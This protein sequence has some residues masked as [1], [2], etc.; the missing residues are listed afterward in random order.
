MSLVFFNTLGSTSLLCENGSLL[1]CCNYLQNF[2]VNNNVYVFKKKSIWH[3]LLAII[4]LCAQGFTNHIVMVKIL[5]DMFV[6][7]CILEKISEQIPSNAGCEIQR[8][9]TCNGAGCQVGNVRLYGK[10]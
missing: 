10:G 1:F 3:A 6:F 9:N 4:D 5:L 8:I 2:V 7:N